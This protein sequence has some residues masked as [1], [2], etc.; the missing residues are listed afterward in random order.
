MGKEISTLTELNQY[1]IINHK[2]SVRLWLHDVVDGAIT[3]GLLTVEN[4]IAGVT[5]GLDELYAASDHNHDTAYAALAHNHDS[6][7]ADIAHNHNTAYAALTHDHDSDYADIAHN[8]NTAYATLTHDHDEDYADIDHTHSIYLK[9][10]YAF[11][12][13]DGTGAREIN[14][15]DESITTPKLIHLYAW[16]STYF[17][18][19]FWYPPMTTGNLLGLNQAGILILY[20]V[21][22]INGPFNITTDLN[23][24]GWNYR[25][26]ILGR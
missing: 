10:A 11:W 18:L 25:V 3:P 23:T 6:D 9:S 2:A 1:E 4:L 21:W 14:L 12:V 13:G 7:Y 5:L 17:Q 24:S 16:N 8:H 26:S 22:S 15:G 19:L 20:L